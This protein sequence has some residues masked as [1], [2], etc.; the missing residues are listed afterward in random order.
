MTDIIQTC[1][2]QRPIAHV[3]A[4]RPND[5]DR[6]TETRRQPQNGASVLWNVGLIKSE[7]QGQ[8]S[9]MVVRQ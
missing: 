6:H 9:M 3:E 8:F 2:P 1:P 7:P 4:R 5:V